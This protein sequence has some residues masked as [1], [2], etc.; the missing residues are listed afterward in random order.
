M[1]IGIV[2]I[3]ILLCILGLFIVFSFTINTKDWHFQPNYVA[4][5]LP[6][7]RNVVEN[8]YVLLLMPNLIILFI[9]TRFGL[10]WIFKGFTRTA[11]Q[12]YYLISWSF[13]T[14]FFIQLSMILFYSINVFATSINSVQIFS[15]VSCFPVFIMMHIY[16]N[17]LD[18]EN[19]RR[20]TFK[21]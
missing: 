12:S 20:N 13:Y 21:K 14:S 10:R 8:N 15:L 18:R 19:Y 11:Y 7:I 17:F 16:M 4:T 1:T 3:D 6:E 9:K 2:F 5:H